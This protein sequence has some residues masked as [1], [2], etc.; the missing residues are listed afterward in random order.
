M[1][2]TAAEGVMHCIKRCSLSGLA[3]SGMVVSGTYR[4]IDEV[5][6]AACAVRGAVLPRLHCHRA[7]PY[8][9]IPKTE[10]RATRLTRE[11][12]RLMTDDLMRIVL[13]VV[14]SH[15]EPALEY[16]PL[17]A[18]EVG[19]ITNVPPSRQGIP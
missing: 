1:A 12:I 6:A 3:T 7:W 11:D 4:K 18:R 15:R 13:F 16:R 10:H 17:H 8:I 9:A 5:T 14:A 19:W 2:T